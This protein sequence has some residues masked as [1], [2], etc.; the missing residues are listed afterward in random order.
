MKICVLY[1]FFRKPQ[2]EHKEN[3]KKRT[4]FSFFQKPPKENKYKNLKKKIKTINSINIYVLEFPDF[5]YVPETSKRK[6]RK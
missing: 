3:K 6:E 2:K 1:S 5:L 4:L